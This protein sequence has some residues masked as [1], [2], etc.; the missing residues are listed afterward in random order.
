MREVA[1][2]GLLEIGNFYE[3]TSKPKA[4]KLYYETAITRYP[5][6]EIAKKC[7]ELL[8]RV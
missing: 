3:R 7:Q 8:K 2:S 6:T 1:A 4:A 5:E